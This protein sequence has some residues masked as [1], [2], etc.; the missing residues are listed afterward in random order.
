MLDVRDKKT[1][2]RIVATF[3]VGA[4]VLLGVRQFA[5]SSGYT[6]TLNK[7]ESIDTA[8]YLVSPLDREAQRGDYVY[9]RM[10]SNPYA[11][12]RLVK[13]IAGVEGDVV[14]TVGSQVYVN[15]ELVGSMKPLTRRGD[16]LTPVESG[17]VPQGHI[18][19]AGEHKDSYDSR[20]GEFGYIP[21]YA[22]KGVARE[23]F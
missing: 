9:F 13:R 3:L 19:V 21:T 20:Y 11:D 17:V 4:V 22:L 7:S 12:G 5:M 16:V 1:N 14:K 18:F 23:L 6:I 8:V 2:R 10:P 15:G